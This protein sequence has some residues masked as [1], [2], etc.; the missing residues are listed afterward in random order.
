MSQQRVIASRFNG[1]PGS[2]NGGYVCGLLAAQ[3]GASAEVTLRKPPPLDHA[4]ALRDEG[5]DEER[6]VSLWD[7]ETLI[8]SAR[9]AEPSV[10]VPDP[11]TLAQ[12]EA[13]EAHYEGHVAHPFPGC[14]VCGP[15]RAAGDGLRLFTG[16]LPQRELVACSFRPGPGFAGADGDVD[17]AIVWSALDCPSYFGGRLRDFGRAAVLG[18]LTATLCRPLAVG[19]PYI[20]VG[21]PILQEGRKWDGGSA[22]FSATGELC[23]FARGRWIELQ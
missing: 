6:H 12:A 17:P 13:A 1:P 5:V 2:G 7:G 16:K 23:A 20:V 4:L 11:P 9:V 15:A 18:R 19:A 3:L 10:V 8:A 14:F 21:W 22:I